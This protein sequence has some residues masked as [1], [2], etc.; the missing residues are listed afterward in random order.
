MKLSVAAW[1][2]VQNKTEDT[3]EGNALY[4]LIEARTFGKRWSAQV[5]IRLDPQQTILVE[6]ALVLVAQEE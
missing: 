3:D 4:D 2:R 5:V 6:R 1:T